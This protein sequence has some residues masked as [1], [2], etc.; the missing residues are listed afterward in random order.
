MQISQVANNGYAVV[1][2]LNVDM[3]KVGGGESKAL[4]I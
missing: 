3:G 4:T 2:I 1:N